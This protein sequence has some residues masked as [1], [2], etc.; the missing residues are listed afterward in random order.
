MTFTCRM[1]PKTIPRYGSLKIFGGEWM[2]CVVIIL[3]A[4]L[5]NGVNWPY[6]LETG[7]VGNMH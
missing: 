2:C 3:N 5:P 7:G 6:Y 4:K 1:Q